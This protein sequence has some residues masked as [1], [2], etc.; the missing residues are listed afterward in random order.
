MRE[1]G[2]R[3]LVRNRYVSAY[4][5]YLESLALVSYNTNPVECETFINKKIDSTTIT[6]QLEFMTKWFTP[7]SSVTYKIY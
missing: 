6:T 1:I 4:A 3:C 5:L 2:L 7:F